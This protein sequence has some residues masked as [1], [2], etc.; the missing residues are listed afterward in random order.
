GGISS[1]AHTPGDSTEVVGC[2]FCLPLKIIAREKSG[3]LILR[4]C[5]GRN[6]KFFGLGIGAGAEVVVDQVELS[7]A[8]VAGAFPVVFDVVAELEDRFGIELSGISAAQ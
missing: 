3:R 7:L 2:P 6:G 8:E 4:F 1:A 5:F